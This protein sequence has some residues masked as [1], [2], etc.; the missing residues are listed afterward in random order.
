ME[1]S[2]L[3]FFISLF[4]VA[5]ICT[6]VAI[7]RQKIINES[8]KNLIM[9]DISDCSINTNKYVG[10]YSVCKKIREIDEDL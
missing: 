4:L 7:I 6:I 5:I 8:D 9:P 2:L 1:K 3:A 10:K